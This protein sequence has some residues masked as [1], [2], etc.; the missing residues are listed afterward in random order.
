MLQITTPD[1]TSWLDQQMKA[2]D[3]T[4]GNA[5]SADREKWINYSTALCAYYEYQRAVQEASAKLS[6]CQD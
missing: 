5:S 3:M 1:F 6:Q 2:I 4:Q